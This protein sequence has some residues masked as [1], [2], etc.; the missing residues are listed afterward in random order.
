MTYQRHS[1]VSGVT[2]SPAAS[3][4]STT[5]TTPASTASTSYWVRASNAAGTADRPPRRSPASA[6]TS[7]LVAFWADDS[8]TAGRAAATAD[9]ARATAYD[10]RATADD[11]RATAD[12]ARAT[13]DDARATADGARAAA[14]D[15]RAAANDARQPP[16]MP[17]GGSATSDAHAAADAARAA[18]SDAR[19]A[20]DAARAAT[21]DAR[22]AADAA[23]AA[24]DHAGTAGRD[25]AKDFFDT[26]TGF[27]RSR[28]TDR[29]D[30][31]RG[32]RDGA[33]CAPAV[34]PGRVA[35]TSS[36]VGGA[37]S[38]SFTTPALTATSSYW[39][40]VTNS[41]GSANSASATVTVTA[42]SAPPPPPLLLA[43]APTVTAQP[44]SQTIGS[45]RAPRSASRR[46]ARPH[47]R[48][49]GTPAPAARPRRQS[50]AQTASA[51]TTP[52]LTSTSSYWVRVS[53][54]A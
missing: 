19:A 26:A 37:T 50:A 12:D 11:A 29:D 34:T 53:N 13:A 2:T 31:R 23:R 10:A 46:A 24:A 5:F 42:P 38:A 8:G 28:R 15:A 7:T 22:A 44:Q 18:T 51:Y 54:A 47:S 52:A 17:P 33:L 39:A 41:A 40:R 20:A 43:V 36:P 6:P 45:G 35:L 3:G 25:G 21:S 4:T 1:G 32:Q 9:D 14:N 27:R 16:L 48:I 49:S 30:E